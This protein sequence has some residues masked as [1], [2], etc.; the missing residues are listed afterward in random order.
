MKELTD[1]QQRAL[2]FVISYLE[3]NGFPPSLKEVGAEIGTNASGAFEVLEALKKKGEIL[4][5][6][7]RPRSI[8]LVNYRVKVEA[9]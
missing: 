9:V 7:K 5:D 4:H 8:Q 3:K 1:R 6:T 2:D